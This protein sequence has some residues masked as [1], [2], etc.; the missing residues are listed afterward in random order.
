MRFSNLDLKYEIALSHFPKFG[1]R[2]LNALLKYFPGAKEAFNAGPKNLAAAGIETKVADE[3]VAFRPDITPDRIMERLGQEEINV[4]GLH[5][6]RYP[7]LLKEIY[8]PPQLLYTKGIM[9][10]GDDLAVAVVGTRMVSAYGRQ[11]AEQMAVGLARESLTVV[12]GLALGT[13]TLAHAACI[14]A[15]GRTV[16]VLGT[17][18][19]N[20]SLYPSSNRYLAQKIISAQGA[21]ISEFPLDTPPWRSN[22][23]QRNRIIAGLAL[24]T[25]VVEAGERS[26]ALITARY[27]L[28]QNREVF[29]VPGSIYSPTSKGTNR[30]IRQGAMAVLEIMD[31]LETLDVKTTCQ[32]I[33][34][35]KLIPATEE[36]ALLLKHLARDPR[37]IDDLIRLTKLT[38]SAINATLTMMEMK[39]LV[40]N[41]GNMEYVITR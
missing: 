38:P 20:N 8:N 39:G 35:K 4:I 3:F 1:P 21:V 19:N 18:V 32:H 30:L 37:H 33:D 7:A 10:D 29:A 40:R 14:K 31:I 17:G 27:A 23:P 22:F 9:E 28:E 11:V 5:D 6:E 34:N 12:S 16:A 26:G 36:E 15:G 24:G 13:D 41:L 25:L 2:R